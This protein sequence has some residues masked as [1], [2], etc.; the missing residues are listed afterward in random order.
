MAPTTSS[1]DSLMEKIVE[2]LRML[3]SEKRDTS[4]ET[5]RAVALTNALTLIGTFEY[6]PESGLTFQRWFS[7]NEHS[8]RTLCESDAER[9]QL[10]LRTLGKSE[11]TQLR[12]RTSPNEPES[13]EYV[14][15]VVILKDMFAVSKSL[16]RR[17]FERCSK[18]AYLRKTAEQ[19]ASNAVLRAD[20]FELSSF[21]LDSLRIFI[22]L[23]SVSD[24][25]YQGLRNVIIKAVDD[26]PSVTADEVRLVMKRYETRTSDAKLNYGV[27]KEDPTTPTVFATTL[28]KPAKKT[29]KNPQAAGRQSVKEQ[30]SCAG[31]GGDHIRRDC[32]F[33]KA[34]CNV[35]RKLGHIDQSLSCNWV[36]RC[37][38]QQGARNF[39]AF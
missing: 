28:R 23:L 6:D 14:A 25:S 17:R 36:E 21:S 5:N 12:G 30:A 1:E 2:A 38:H 37:L 8:F 10:L 39:A 18:I 4:Q 16:F 35:C 27:T 7:K 29:A 33:R 31:C 26:K 22:M 34:K 13:L 3:A 32:K 24:P 15:L 19:I 20:D 11:Y 9:R